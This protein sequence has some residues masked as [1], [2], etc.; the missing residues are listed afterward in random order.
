MNCETASEL[1]PELLSGSMGREAE[2][3]VLSHL[4]Q[5][6]EC[7]RELAF[8][9]QVAEA[10]ETEAESAEMSAGL[11]EEA[12]ENLFGARALSAVQ[13]LRLAGRALG[14]AGSACKLALLVTGF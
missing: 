14:L 1:L 2:M 3:E 13:G 12:R 4:A 8:W 10:A 6:A 11:F 5:C 9:A 7:R